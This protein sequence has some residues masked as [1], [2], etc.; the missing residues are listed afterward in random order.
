MV[1]LWYLT[2]LSTTEYKIHQ[3]CINVVIG[4]A[5]VQFIIVF[6]FI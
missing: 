6:F 4:N 2:P 3:S 5:S 1:M